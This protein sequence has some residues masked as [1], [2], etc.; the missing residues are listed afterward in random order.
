[1]GNKENPGKGAMF[2]EIAK[3]FFQ[4]KGI[5]LKR[6]FVVNVGITASAK[7]SVWNE[8]MYCFLV[9]LNEYRKIL[10]VLKSTRRG[11]TLTNYYIKRYEHLIP[12]GVEFGNIIRSHVKGIA[13]IHV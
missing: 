5:S 11:E 2:E 7:M 10:F 4:Q 12:R 13:F 8:A 9:A 6:P 1:M 3:V